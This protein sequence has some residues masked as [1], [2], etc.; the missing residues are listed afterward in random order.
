MIRGWAYVL[1]VAV[2]VAIALPRTVLAGDDVGF[3]RGDGNQDTEVDVSDVVCVLDFLFVGNS[4]CAQ[5]ACL[6]ALDADDDEE[7]AVTDA[8]YLLGFLFLGSDEPPSPFAS[9]GPDLS[10]G[11]EQRIDCESYSACVEVELPSFSSPEECASCHPRQYNEWLGSMHS[12]AGHSPVFNALELAGNL[13]SENALR[14]G[15]SSELFCIKCHNSVGTALGEIPPPDA[16]GS[17]EPA[18]AHANELTIRGVQCDVCH[19]VRDSH[20]EITQFQQ[21]AHGD[22]AG[23]ANAAF[24][25]EAGVTRFGPIAD[26]VPT[27]AHLS[28]EGE[29]GIFRSG[30]F[31]AMCHDVRIPGENRHNGEPFLRLENLFTEWD[32]GPY[33]DPAD[34]RNL[35]RSTVTC[36]DCHMSLFPWGPP[37][38]Y[39]SGRVAEMSD[40]GTPPPRQRVSTHYFTAV[41]KAL[42]DFPNQSGDHVDEF[43]NPASQDARR[44]RYLELAATMT[45]DETVRTL[46]VS[47][48]SEMLPVK[49]T[50]KNF[51]TGHGLPSGF[52][53]ERQF[54]VQLDVVDADGEILYQSGHLEDRAHPETGE[55]TPDGYLGDEDLLD[56]D[57]EFDLS[58]GEATLKRGPD[59]NERPESNKGIVLLQNQ[60][61]RVDDGGTPDDPSDDSEEEVYLP[62]LANEIDNSIALAPFE[63]RTYTYDVDVPRGTPGPIS[64]RARLV[65]RQFPPYFVRFLARILPD[66]MSEETVD[67]L[68]IVEMANAELSVTVDGVEEPQPTCIDYEFD[69]QPIWS[70]RCVPCHGSIQPFA[71]LDLSP[72]VSY[73][74]LVNAQSLMLDGEK[75]VTP[76][77]NSPVPGGAFLLEKLM[78][79]SPRVGKPMPAGGALQLSDREILILRTW[80]EEGA[81]RSVEDECPEE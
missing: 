77:N 70:R 46:D 5:A 71:D 34:S 60:F 20:P 52:S 39:A 2:C 66:V 57:L 80:I 23:V 29:A 9:C 59:Y 56:K 73:D 53:Q 50:L 8:V 40:E 43:G 36:Q 79:D 17:I 74:N 31:C 16:D 28:A 33:N 38:T 72:A 6:D 42:V 30:K 67:R 25:L 64:I 75:L 68:D 12:Y 69:V 18:F 13:L 3:R 48:R 62:F 27:S 76:F 15:G 26:P 10:R 51:M 14:P 63:A 54:W 49:V 1:P 32:S 61:L 24:R 45:L 35:F 78:L 21:E 11:V 19:F 55:M 44:R 65:F 4:A 37:G 58:T 22:R 41:D 81:R 47:D 7:L